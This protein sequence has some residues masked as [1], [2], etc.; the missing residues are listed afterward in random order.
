MVQPEPGFIVGPLSNALGFVLDPI[1]NFVNAISP[2]LAFGI[3]IIIFTI[4]IRVILLPLSIKMHKN[5]ENLRKLQPDIAKINEKY[6]NA[7]DRDSMAKKNQDI[8]KLYAENGANPFSGCLPALIQLP[9]FIT[10]FSMLQRPYLYITSL[11]NVYNQIAE[12]LMSVPG[13]YS[14][15]FTT[16]SLGLDRLPANMEILLTNQY[17]LVRLFNVY[18]PEDWDMLISLLPEYVHQPIINLLYQKD[19]IEHF[20]TISLVQPSGVLLPGVIIPILA[21]VSTFLSSRL[22]LK[23]SQQPAGDNTAMKIQQNVLL[24]A[25]PLMMGFITISTPAGV[26]LYWASS[27]VFHLVQHITLNKILNRKKMHVDEE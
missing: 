9:I 4:F 12:Y 2:S 13:Y 16:P 1:F 5:A 19:V 15:I 24:Y 7:K 3:S 22:M 20:L 14:Y 26:G 25:M 6:K 10:L 23:Q 8:Q 27:N 11:G 18:G 17:D 21:T